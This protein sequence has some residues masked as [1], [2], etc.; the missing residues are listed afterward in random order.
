M[1]PFLT[2][3]EIQEKIQKKEI[4]PQE[5]I[6]FFRK[7]LEKYNAQVN[8]VIEIFP[9]P[10]SHKEGLLNGVPGIIKDN[11]AQNGHITSCGSKM[12]SNYVAPY[13]ATIIQHLKE[14]GAP[15]LGRANMDEFAMGSTGEFS[16]YGPAYNPW[17]TT[18]T[19]G[20]SSSGVAA[21]VAAG[22][23]P[24]GIGSETGGSVRMPSAF[25]NLVGLYPTYGRF[26]R[27]GLIAFASS[28]D[29]VGPLTRTVYDNALIASIIS[30]HDSL[31]GTSLSTP[32]ID[33]TKH[34][35]GKLPQNLKIGIIREALESEGIDPEIKESFKESI[36]HLEQMGA[37]I[38]VIDLPNLKYG[39]AVYFVLSRAEAASNLSRFDGTLYGKRAKNAKDLHDMYIKTRHDSFGQE[40]KLRML[41]GNYVLSSLHSDAF[42]KKA[43]KV[44]SLIRSE[45]ES[46]FHDV[47]LLMSPTTTALPFKIGKDIQDPLKVYM[48]DYFTVPF[49]VA[50]VPCLS[51]P[52]R[53]SKKGLPIGF[54]FIGPKLSEELIYKVAHAYQQNTDFHNKVPKGFE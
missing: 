11:I 39:I 17:D 27:Y 5:V 47:D 33:F 32:K 44:R 19:P 35:N 24:W 42:Y 40:V 18:R 34:L 14:E 13:D 41:M 20:G 15:I 22:L 29:Q 10:T 43:L 21:S 38:K 3:K 54:Q 2:I 12:L 26:S 4:L 23:V 7:R 46:V 48:A 9:E 37:T 49:C 28:T 30:G 16:T 50:G 45:L 53:P 36:K 25:C 6:S 8:A 1:K 31:D 52:G 51:L